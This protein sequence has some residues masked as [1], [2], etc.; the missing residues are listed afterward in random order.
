MSLLANLP[1][2]SP[3]ELSIKSFPRRPKKRPLSR[4]TVPSHLKT[5]RNSIVIWRANWVSIK[6]RTRFKGKATQ[7]WTIPLVAI[8]RVSKVIVSIRTKYQPKISITRRNSKTWPAPYRIR[9]IAAS[10]KTWFHWKLQLWVPGSLTILLNQVKIMTLWLLPQTSQLDIITIHYCL[11]RKLGI[12]RTIKNLRNHNFQKL[13]LLARRILRA[14]NISLT[15]M[16]VSRILEKLHRK[17]PLKMFWESWESKF[18]T[19][20]NRS[21][22]PEAKKMH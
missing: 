5:W 6:F 18:S 7:H 15:S 13:K 8:L 1:G 9:A 12:R 4:A 2:T 10:T 11:I 14:Y 21:L 19:G 17:S 22:K 16:L 3:L 20:R